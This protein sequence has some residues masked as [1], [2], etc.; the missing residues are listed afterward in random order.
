MYLFVCFLFVVYKLP[1]KTCFTVS[2][3]SADLIQ[4]CREQDI[5]MLRHIAPYHVECWTVWL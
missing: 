5:Y 3:L 4:N 1:Q 2:N